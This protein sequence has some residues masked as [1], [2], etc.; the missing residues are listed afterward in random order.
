MARLAS[1]TENIKEH[2]PVVVIGSGYGGGIAASRLA[3]AG[4]QVCVLE[5]G[6]EFQPG[7]YP[8]T[9]AE[10]L[11]DVQADTPKGHIGSRT[12]LLDFRVNDDINVVVGCGLGGTSLINVNVS[13]HAERRVFEDA[14]WPQAL[15]D[16]LD[17]LVADGYHR[18]EEMLK[19]TPYPDDFP[20]LPKLEALEKSAKYMNEKFYRPPINVTFKDGVNHVGVEQ[21]ACKLCG[22][23][24]TGCNYSAKNTLIMN[25]LPDAKN[26]GAEL[27]TQ[28]SVRHVKRQGARWLVHYQLV[29]SGREK[30]DAPTMF[31]S[32]DI[33]VLAA[34]ALGSTEILLRSKENG[35]SLSDELGQAF[36]GNGNVLGLAYNADQPIESVGYGNRPPDEMPP[37]GPC[38]TGIIDMREQPQLADGME[39]EEGVFPGALS[40]LLPAGLDALAK[41]SG[42][43]TD[44]GLGDYVREKK[45]ELDS[46]VRG[47]YHG[48]VHN[49]QVYLGISHDDS[50]G[51]MYLKNDGLR[52]DWPG[53]GQQPVFNRLNGRLEEATR[54]LGGTFINNPLWSQLLGRNLMS[55]HPL[56]GCGMAEAAEHG[57]VNHKGQVFSKNQGTEV[58]D[59]LYVSD[60]SV[61][62]H[63]V[64]VNPLMTI[65]ALAER[66]C[67]LLAADRGWEINYDL[68]SAP[69]TAPEPLQLGV[70]FTETMKGFFSTQVKADDGYEEGARIDQSED[71]RFEFI[72]TI[73]VDDLDRML[74]DPNYTAE[75]IGSVNA[76]A[77][78]SEPLTVT[79]GGFNLFVESK[80]NVD[81]R[82]MRYRMKMTAE[83]GKVYYFTGFKVIRADSGLDIWSD[84]TTLYITVYDGDSAESPVL[85]KGVL[86]IQP[87]DFM[88]QL[89]TMQAKNAENT[90]QRLEAIARFG[91]FFAGVLFDVY[92]G[93]FAKPNVFN[94]DAPPRKL[95]PLRVDA[96][97]VHFFNTSDGVQLRLTRYQGGSKGPVMLL[98][99][100]GVSSLIFSLDTIETNLLEYLYAHGYDVWLL[101][102]RA[103]I[104]LPA[105]EMKSTADDVATKDYPAAVAKVRELTGANDIQV[106]AH[107]YGSTTFFMGLLAGLDGVRSAV[108]SQIATHIKAPGLTRLKSGL[109]L[110]SLL[111]AVGVD[112]LTAY[113]DRHTNWRERLYDAALRLY[114]L[115]EEEH[116]NSPVC[117][118]ISFMY[119]LLYEHDQLNLATHN[120]L[121]ETFGVANI[122]A[123]EHLALMTRRGH[124]VTADNQD[125]YLPH[126]D[127]LAIPIAFIHGAEN[128]C[129]LPES[130]EITYNLLR[131][132]NG[133]GL[134]SRHVIPNYGHI[135]CIFGQNA[136]NDVY[137]F[138]LHHLEKTA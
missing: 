59:G 31:V 43:D 11:A 10:A 133:R 37:V 132:K 123:F 122:D 20:T 67:V 107:C 36:S 69:Q 79:G 3:R 97:E 19:P 13:L 102:Y 104:D 72:L 71:S 117:H 35:L 41:V 131:E 105:A 108:S 110:P 86:K 38:I 14:R 4:Q 65:S 81:T 21:K 32:A 84:T 82:N 7:E 126:L 23:C 90:G 9:E 24:V 115:E 130:T 128:E 92:G 85:G 136:A 18:A 120:T 62:P 51:R 57:V 100:L 17:T 95:R 94:P 44:R 47:A 29:K 111:D 61:I 30:F 106:V 1:P 56:G 8:D 114:P 76:P 45:R 138:I 34:G 135:D 109:H 63:S 48:A 22:D 40:S 64:G 83:D 125:I 121:H 46:L 98:H 2:Y 66:S 27:Y 91:K 6:K 50:A 129:F 118:R 73:T 88:R 112:S 77:L 89:T 53:V 96:P 124:L 116:C 58:H 39:I 60:G 5:R 12:G 68:P 101:D 26:H 93:I 75:M 28:V 113:V 54:A 80:D 78:S 49:T 42:K 127:R 15:R 119:A 137:P 134:Y 55:V 74:A 70:Q 52:I 99:G 87:L 16:D 25:Y 103:S 33:V